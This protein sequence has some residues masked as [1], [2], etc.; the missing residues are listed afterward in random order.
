MQAIIDKL[1]AELQEK[2]LTA[3]K[4]LEKKD[5]KI[6]KKEIVVEKTT[7]PPSEKKSLL[8]RAFTQRQKLE[9]S[10]S[11]RKTEESKGKQ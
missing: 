2:E 5:P 8:K 11:P 7:S 10:F 4:Q 1:K 6:A 3:T 9:S